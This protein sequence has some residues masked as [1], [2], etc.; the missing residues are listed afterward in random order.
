MADQ[1][2]RLSSKFHKTEKENLRKILKNQTEN[3]SEKITKKGYWL[4]K[5]KKMG[6]W[7]WNLEN[8]ILILKNKISK[9][10]K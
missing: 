5:I 1:K 4:R 8:G 2:D 10:C 7:F 9:N 6:F 3:S